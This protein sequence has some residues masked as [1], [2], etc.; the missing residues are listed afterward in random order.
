MRHRFANALAEPEQAA[1]GHQVL[2]L[3]VDQF[4]V[5]PEDVV[6]PRARRMLQLEDGLRVEQVRRSVA[7]PLVFA[8]RCQVLVTHQRRRPPGKPQRAAP[9][10]RPR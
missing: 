8:A 1:Q 5:V 2:G 10:S 9:R 4:R 7:T 3:L 6:S